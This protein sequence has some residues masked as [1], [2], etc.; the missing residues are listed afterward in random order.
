MHSYYVYLLRELRLAF[1]HI[2]N[3]RLRHARRRFLHD[4][5]EIFLHLFTSLAKDLA[6]R[7]NLRQSL[8]GRSGAARYY[9]EGD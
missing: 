7:S 1:G 8:R 9:G 2:G 4:F 6:V 3:L 5:V